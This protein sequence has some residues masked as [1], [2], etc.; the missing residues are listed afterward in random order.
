MDNQLNPTSVIQ[1]K[2]S[3]VLEIPVPHEYKFNAS[4]RKIRGHQLF[5]W[6]PSTGQIELIKT[7]PELEIIKVGVIEKVHHKVN[8]DAGIVYLQ[9]LNFKNAVKRVLKMIAEIKQG[10]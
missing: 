7:K 1:D 8:Q 6:N 4:I 9:A 10:R 5:G 2:L 3:T